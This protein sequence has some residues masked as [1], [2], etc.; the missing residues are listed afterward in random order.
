MGFFMNIINKILGLI[1]GAMPALRK[2][3]EAL[4]ELFDKLGNDKAAAVTQQAEELAKWVEA[5]HDKTVEWFTKMYPDLQ[6][7]LQEWA[8]LP[9][10]MYV[11]TNVM[12]DQSVDLHTAI[13]AAQLGA[14]EIKFKP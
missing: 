4:A 13:T 7:L 9:E 1:P 2:V 12:K 11:M 3:L 10:F 8:K 5:N 14:N 6:A